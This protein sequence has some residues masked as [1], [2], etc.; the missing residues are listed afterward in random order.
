MLIWLLSN[1][2]VLCLV[3]N[4]CNQAKNRGLSG[5]FSVFKLSHFSPFQQYSL[6]Q[7]MK[8][9]KLY[10]MMPSLINSIAAQVRG[11]FLTKKVYLAFGELIFL[12]I[13]RFD[14]EAGTDIDGNSTPPRMRGSSVL[15]DYFLGG[16][17]NY[18]AKIMIRRIKSYL[19]TVPYNMLKNRNVA[20]ARH[21]NVCQ[22]GNQSI[23]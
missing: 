3:L 14:C 1:R 20:L 12:R 10:F 18:Y 23:S 2:H 4:A 15:E 8:L 17:F 7:S 22:R 16:Q 5:K 9:L 21:K 6:C 13:N 19:K 11:W